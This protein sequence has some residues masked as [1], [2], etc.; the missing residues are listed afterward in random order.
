[1]DEL[2]RLTVRLRELVKRHEAAPKT[3]ID[4]LRQ[5]ESEIA[6]VEALRERTVS[7]LTQRLITQVAA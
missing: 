3:G 6:R 2:D 4:L 7:F 1:M 5:L